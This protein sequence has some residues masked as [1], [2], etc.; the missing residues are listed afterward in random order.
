MD[1]AGVNKVGQGMVLVFLYLLALWDSS[2]QSFNTRH[3][4]AIVCEVVVADIETRHH[5]DGKKYSRGGTE[6]IF[7][8]TCTYWHLG[9]KAASMMA[10]ETPSSLPLKSASTI[11]V[12]IV[13]GGPSL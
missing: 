11:D 7:S 1:G 3:V 12:S 2:S 9:R 5:P 10:P 6:G 4:I 8:C 13:T